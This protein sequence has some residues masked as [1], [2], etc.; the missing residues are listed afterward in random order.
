MKKLLCVVHT[1]DELIKVKRI[2][3]DKN[4]PY[5]AKTP[6]LPML[7]NFLN[8]FFFHVLTTGIDRRSEHI[9]IYVEEEYIGIAKSLI[10][11]IIF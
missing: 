3:D 11:N 4:I 2:L 5:K 9:S 6:I 7:Q 1:T 8:L 10:Q